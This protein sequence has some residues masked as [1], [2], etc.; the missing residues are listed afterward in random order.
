MEEG[1]CSPVGPVKSHI[2]SPRV[3]HLSAWL[4]LAYSTP[5]YSSPQEVGEEEAEDKQILKKT[6]QTNSGSWHIDQDLD[7]KLCLGSRKYEGSGGQLKLR[8]Q[9][10]TPKKKMGPMEDNFNSCHN[11]RSIRRTQQGMKFKVF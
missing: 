7:T 2:P 1:A 3:L 9:S 10:P 5:T 8:D 6:K 11:L 4:K